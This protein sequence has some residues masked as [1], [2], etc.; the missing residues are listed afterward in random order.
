MDARF[1]GTVSCKDLIVA[2]DCVLPY[3]TAALFCREA[4]HL[5]ITN[6]G[7]LLRKRR[8]IEMIHEHLNERSAMQI[9]QTRQLPNHP[10]MSKPLNRFTVFPIL[11]ADQNHAMH[12]QLRCMQ[13]RQCQQSVVDRSQGTPRCENHRQFQLYRHVQNKLLLID[14]H[15]HS[16]RALNDQPIVRQMPGQSNLR[17]I[18]LYSRPARRQIRRDRWNKFV[19]FI[20]RPVG[21]N[22]RQPH[23]CHPVR[24]F[25]CPRLNRLPVNRVQ[26][27]AQERGQHGFSNS[28]VCASDEKVMPHARTAVACPALVQMSLRARH[29]FSDDRSWFKSRCSIKPV[30]EK[31]SRAFS[32][33]T[34]GGRIAR[35]ANPSLCK[36]SAA[37][38]ASS[39]EPIIAGTIC[40]FV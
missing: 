35:T 16:T 33:G 25:K 21:P 14:R 5:S 15:E 30:N 13:R 8:S 38:S 34:V 10:H 29:S 17:K 28:R 9:W 12:G 3:G 24:T 27:C 20:E 31:R 39:F 7:S 26:S 18:N 36:D 32:F 4:R 19:N 40:E 2:P 23:H 1:L 37:S 6:H 22:S 11:I